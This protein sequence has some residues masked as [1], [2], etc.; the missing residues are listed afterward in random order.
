MYWSTCLLVAAQLTGSEPQLEVEV[1]GTELRV[2]TWNVLADPALA[3]E[4]LPALLDHLKTARADIIA[5]QEAAPWFTRKLLAEPWVRRYAV[6][7]KDG[8]PIAPRGVMV[9][10]RLPIAKTEVLALPGRQ[11]RA[12]IIAWV[13]HVRPQATSEG[14]L[15]VVTAHLE[16]FLED[17]PTRAKQIAHIQAHL[18]KRGA[19]DAIFLGD[20][21]FGDGAEPE[22]SALDAGWVD[23]WTATQA[24][25]P[26]L[27]WVNEVNPMAKAG[28]F[29]GEPSRRLDRILVRS[30]S[31]APQSARILGDEPV[32]AER[33]EVFPSDHFGVLA[34]LKATA[35]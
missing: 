13:E 15:A 17:G 28:A 1:R 11:R 26:G 24:D 16:S 30:P 10:S 3:E 21:N 6:T 29:P 12:A 7:R 2:L 27:T 34:E 25:A 32:S 35:P 22:T 8:R 33:P 4:R 23:A 14:R 18:K 5:L 9:L 19:T 20:M 31:F